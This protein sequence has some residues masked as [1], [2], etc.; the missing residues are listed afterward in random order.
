LCSRDLIGTQ[1]TAAAITIPPHKHSIFR[2][3]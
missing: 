2:I 1:I 3:I